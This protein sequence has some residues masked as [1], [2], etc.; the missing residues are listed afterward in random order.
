MKSLQ[1]AEIWVYPLKSMGGIS[2]TEARVLPK[3]LELDRR[4]MLVD[5]TG[6]FITGREYPILS[7]FQ[8]TLDKQL[9][10]I[11]FNH[12]SIDIPVN[13]AAGPTVQAIVWNDMVSVQEVSDRHNHWFSERLGKRVRLVH[14]PEENPR[15]VDPLLTPQN[16]H[17][18]LSDAY[19]FLII[20][21][22]SLDDLNTRLDNP[23]A[24]NRFRPNFV[25]TGGNAFEEDTW[26][27]FSIG[28]N[29]FVCV[30]HCSRCVLTTIDPETGEKGVEPLKTLASYRK[31]NNKIY[32][33]QNVLA[34]DADRIRAG[35]V[36]RVESMKT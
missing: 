22:S 19:P 31:Q 32:F 25:F 10:T 6:M 16:T 30:K 33:G 9:L 29:R 3:G 5:E 4:W 20:G 1:L 2:L 34:L 24:M 36:I 8:L 35:D 13:N 17:T 14:F 27:N 18:S 15:P 23:V 11:T 21:Q 12:E 26:K 7:L 28:T